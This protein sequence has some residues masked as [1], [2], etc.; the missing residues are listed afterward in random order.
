MLFLGS[1]FTCKVTDTEKASVSGVALKSAAVNQPAA[2]VID[3]QGAEVSAC[4]VMVLSPS[5]VHLPINITGS[6]P[7]KVQAGFTPV[8]VGKFF[9]RCSKSSPLS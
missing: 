2:I 4:N 9:I 5:G 7:N 3:P 6:L 8:E 1:P